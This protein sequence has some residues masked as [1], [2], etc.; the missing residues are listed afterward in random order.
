[1][2]QIYQLSEVAENNGK[3]GKPVWIIYKG[4]VYDVT[5]FVKNHPG[6]E[7]LILEVAGKDATKA[8]NGAGHSS[9][10]V[11]DLKKY[12]IGEVAINSQPT[13]ANA[14]PTS[15]TKSPTEQKLP[16]KEPMKPSSSSSFLCCC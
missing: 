3:K 11:N 12:K 6:G 13:T 15:A 5:G 7:D 16:P 1:M 2:S 8:F 14:A 10:A 9:D 4:N